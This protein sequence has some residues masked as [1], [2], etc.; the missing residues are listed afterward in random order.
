MSK[1]SPQRLG[2]GL[3]ALIGQRKPPPQTAQP[4]PIQSNTGPQELIVN[5]I[6]TNPNQPRTHFSETA[7]QELAQSIRSAGMIQP[8]LVRAKAGGFELIAGERR[9][10]AAQI[11]GLKKIPAL[12]RD[13][14]DRQAAEIALI[15]NLQREDLKPLERARAYQQYLETQG[16]TPEELAHRLGESRA[17]VANYIRL[18]SLPEEIQQML[19]WGE[20]GMGHARAL[21]GVRDPQR[22]LSLARLAVRRNLAVRQVEALAKATE[23]ADRPKPEEPSA[24]SRNKHYA[25]VERSLSRATGLK[26]R[27][28]PGKKKNTGRVV[29]HYNSLEE[30][31]RL[32]DLLG[33]HEDG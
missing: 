29:L 22:Q 15:E 31:D 28:I 23:E 16:G 21:I 3:N 26:T 4:N 14:S 32:A 9:L 27:L 7:L 8:I 20:L 24:P 5:D 10:R 18:L 17:N 2:K 19:E 6:R 30:F 1:N 25:E 12:V 13:V 33:A 11:A